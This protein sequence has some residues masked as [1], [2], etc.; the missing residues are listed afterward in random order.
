MKK[1]LFRIECDNALAATLRDRVAEALRERQKTHP[2]YPHL[3]KEK[4]SSRPRKMR[5]TAYLRFRLWDGQFRGRPLPGIAAAMQAG[6]WL[7]QRLH[8]GKKK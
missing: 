6:R 2:D 1:N 7:A 3:W 4:I 8:M 5:P